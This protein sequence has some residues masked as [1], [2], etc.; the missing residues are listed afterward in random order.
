MAAYSVKDAVDLC[1]QAYRKLENFEDRPDI[2]PTTASE[3]NVYWSKRCWGN[4]MDGITPERGLWM[5]DRPYGGSTS[6]KPRR[7][8]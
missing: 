3:I 5:Q 7:I 1:N 6:D 2:N 4:P 8:I